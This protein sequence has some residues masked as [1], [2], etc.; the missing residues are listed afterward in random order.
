MQCYCLAPYV[1]K[2]YKRSIIVLLSHGVTSELPIPENQLEQKITRNH[3]PNSFI[4]GELTSLLETFAAKWCWLVVMEVA[5]YLNLISSLPTDGYCQVLRHH[6][7]LQN[8]TEPE[9]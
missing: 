4:K 7:M 9:K 5:K 6:F 2:L 3:K 1:V 8:L